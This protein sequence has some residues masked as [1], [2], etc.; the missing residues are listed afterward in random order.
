M[1]KTPTEGYALLDF[2]NISVVMPVSDAVAAF[3]ALSRGEVVEY[4]WANRAHKRVT[5]PGRAPMLK[6]FSATQYAT[7]AL[8]DNNT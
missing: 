6:M 7:L 2:G 5:D 4:D 1:A 8:D 3:A